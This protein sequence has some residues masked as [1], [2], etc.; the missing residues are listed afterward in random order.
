MAQNIYKANR[1]I[2][3]NV[4]NHLN[5]SSNYLGRYIY[6]YAKKID[7]NVIYLNKDDNEAIYYGIDV[8]SGG[9]GVKHDS[10]ISSIFN[11]QN[12]ILNYDNTINAGFE[13]NKL[14]IRQIIP[15][16]FYFSLNDILSEVEK[17]TF[18]GAE[19]SVSGKW[20]KDGLE[21]KLHGFNLCLSQNSMVFRM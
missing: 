18:Y 4:G 5:D 3:V 16:S 2:R 14:I 13:R 15:L 12:S 20:I 21:I 19:L 17:A 11:K 6:D 1:K 8:I 7:N 10:V 9:F